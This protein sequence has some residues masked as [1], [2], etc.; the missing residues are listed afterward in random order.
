MPMCGWTPQLELRLGAKQGFGRVKHIDT[1]FLWVQAM[2]IEG[3][4]SFGKNPAKEMPSDLLT[5]HVDAATMQSGWIENEISVRREQP[6]TES[7]ILSVDRGD[8]CAETWES[9]HRMFWRCELWWL[10]LCNLKHTSRRAD[11]IFVDTC[12]RAGR[13]Q[14]RF[15]ESCDNSMRQ[16]SS[17]SCVFRFC[18]SEFNCG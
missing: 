12:R 7:V 1:V 18:S 14:C 4:I 16:C 17:C 5:K 8:C 15:R 10:F 11:G 13:R 9:G 2:V 6:N 3:K